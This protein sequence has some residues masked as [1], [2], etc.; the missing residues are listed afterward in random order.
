MVKQ[1]ILVCVFNAGKCK[2]CVFSDPGSFTSMPL[3]PALRCSTVQLSNGLEIPILGI[4]LYN[5]LNVQEKQSSIIPMDYRCQD[6]RTSSSLFLKL[7][8]VNLY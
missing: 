3:F 1:A 2:D 8:E 5:V 4:G 7:L 6:V